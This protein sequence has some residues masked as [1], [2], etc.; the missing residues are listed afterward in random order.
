MDATVE[1]FGS[2]S[3]GEL[4]QM[5][6]LYP[7]NSCNPNKGPNVKICTLGAALV[8]CTI[9]GGASETD[10]YLSDVLLGYETVKD[11]EH[12]PPYFGVIVGRV[13]GRIQKGRFNPPGS[14]K[15]GLSYVVWTVRR[16]DRHSVLLEHI[17]PDGADG[18]PGK[19]TV[20]VEYEFRETSNEQ[21]VLELSI[22]YHASLSNN[23]PNR[24]FC[25][26]SLTNHAYWNLA[27]HTTGREG[28]ARHYL[29][30][31]ASRYAELR[32]KDLI[33]T[34]RILPIPAGS[35]LDFREP[36]ALGSGLSI[37]G[38]PDGTGYDD[39]YVFDQDRSPSEP[40]VIVNEPESHRRMRVYTDQPGMQLYTAFYLNPK[41]DPI[42][43]EGHRYMPYSG[44]C[45]ETEGYP[46]ACNQPDFPAVI[47]QS[48][49]AAYVQRTTFRFDCI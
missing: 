29:Q 23:S 21:D 45:L 10:K 28:L 34:G 38:G 22:T 4:V 48:G 14:D 40:A 36:R 26:V 16:A 2:N 1:P 25:P 15:E 43:K 3:R 31:R 27:G 42:G 33:P 13:A 19:L 12:N 8:S 47:L 9:P 30:I 35:P 39:Y 17:S 5:I 6:T 41:T 46:D 11:Y 49:G 18:F 44:F 32:P 7:S 20:Q 24:V 37:V